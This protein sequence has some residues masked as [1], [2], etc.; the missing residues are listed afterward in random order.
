[1]GVKDAVHWDVL[2]DRHNR[3]LLQGADRT[4]KDGTLNV[5]PIEEHIVRGVY[6]PRQTLI[7][8]R[9]ARGDKT[10]MAIPE[11]NECR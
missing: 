6:R 8:R 1:M 2:T 11:C 4:R 5:A 9:S 7:A 3:E 10:Y